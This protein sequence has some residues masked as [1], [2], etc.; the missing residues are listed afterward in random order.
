VGGGGE[1]RWR[2]GEETTGEVTEET[3]TGEIIDTK[4]DEKVMCML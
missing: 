1:R 2:G 3:R 4:G